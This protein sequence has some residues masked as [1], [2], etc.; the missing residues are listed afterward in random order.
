MSNLIYEMSRNCE[1]NAHHIF[2][3]SRVSSCTVIDGKEKQNIRSWNQQMFPPWLKKKKKKKRLK[4]LI[5]YQNSWQLICFWS[6][7]HLIDWD[8]PK[9]IFKS[10]FIGMK[11]QPVEVLTHYTVPPAGKWALWCGNG[12]HYDCK[13]RNLSRHQDANWSAN[14]CFL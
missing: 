10:L 6:I 2:Q 3:E 7:E 9:R 4:G 1:K 5:N 14:V 13:T 8:G 11:T 12:L